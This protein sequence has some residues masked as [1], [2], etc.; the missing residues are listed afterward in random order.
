MSFV[1]Q[2]L[3]TATA[4]IAAHIGIL[5]VLSGGAPSL[6]SAFV[7]ELIIRWT[8]AALFANSITWPMPQFFTALIVGGLS[9][10]NMA[11]IVLTFQGQLAFFQRALLTNGT[12]A[13]G[14]AIGATLAAML[15]SKRT[16]A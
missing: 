1:A 14:L 13:V 10:V 9:A 2:V 16:H 12:G 3:I 5:F 15:I 6:S 4:A 11:F 8:I 7:Q